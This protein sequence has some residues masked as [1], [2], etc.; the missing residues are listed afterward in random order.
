VTATARRTGPG[1]VVVEISVA[2]GYHINAS[3]VPQGL[4]PTRLAVYGVDSRITY[5]SANE[6]LSLPGGQGVGIYRG[7]VEVRVDLDG[8]GQGVRMSLR[9]QPCSELACLEVRVVE[10]E[11]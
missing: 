9:F 4:Y 6:S 8:S 2:E 10:L 3:E 5:P 1:Q 7:R 11:V